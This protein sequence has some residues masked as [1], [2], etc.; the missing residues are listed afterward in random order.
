[1]AIRNLRVGGIVLCGGR[2]QRMGKPKAWL[3]VGSE[4]LLQ[5][6][7]RIASGVVDPV[8]VAGHRGQDIPPLN[9]GIAVVHDLK[10]NC[11]PL[12]GIAAG[13]EALANHCEAAFVAS[14]DHPLVKPEFIRRLV[15][16]L[17]DSPGIL[18]LHDGQSY[19]LLAVY[20]LD[21]RA[22]LDGLLARGD[23]R[24]RDFAKRCGA[25]TVES[26]DLTSADPKLTCRRT[27]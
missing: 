23:L 7:V 8:V 6:V 26:T 18:P 2:S 21:T 20:R 19:P 4:Y 12:A 24:V 16:L 22:V 5:R 11:G 25:R 27:T 17:G 1:M 13:F 14:C 15:E 10:E 3:T 9:D